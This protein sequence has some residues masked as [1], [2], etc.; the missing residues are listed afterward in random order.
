M[1]FDVRMLA[2]II[3]LLFNQLLAVLVIIA[4]G[5]ILTAVSRLNFVLSKLD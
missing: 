4:V 5:S 2:L 1:T 3:G